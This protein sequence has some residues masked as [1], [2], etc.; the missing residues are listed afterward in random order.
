MDK[1]PTVTV[2]ES[3]AF[4]NPSANGVS[5]SPYGGG[6]SD[7]RRDSAVALN[8]PNPREAIDGRA[9]GFPI[10]NPEGNMT[11]SSSKASEPDNGHGSLS[12][13]N[14]MTGTV[15]KT[16]E[17]MKDSPKNEAGPSKGPVLPPFTAVSRA[18]ETPLAQASR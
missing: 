1:L 16:P 17:P 8:S 11:S 15:G 5:G 18:V 2:S 7:S 14:A 6:V 4:L 3:E 12:R 13:R 10:I 9:S